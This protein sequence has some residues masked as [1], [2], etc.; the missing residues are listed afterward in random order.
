MRDA[1]MTGCSS[2]GRGGGTL[3]IAFAKA[4]ALRDFLLNNSPCFFF[5]VSK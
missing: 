3:A 1:L 5:Y 2:G 4:R